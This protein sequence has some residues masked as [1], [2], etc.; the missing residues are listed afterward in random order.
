MKKSFTDGLR[1]LLPN[2]MHVTCWAHILSLVGQEFRG[3]FELTDSLVAVMKAIFSHVPGRQ[4]RY[5]THLCDCV[6]TDVMMPPN[7]V[8][9][10]WNMWFSA[11][12]YH[13]QH[14]QYYRTFVENELAQCGS[15]VQ[16]HK[17]LD[18]LQE[19]SALVLQAELEFLSV[20]C[21]RLMNTLKALEN[22]DLHAVT[23]HNT[24]SD[25]LSCL[26]NPGFPFA[27]AA[28]EMAMT[29]AAAK[30]QGYVEQDIQPAHHLLHSTP[31][32][33]QGGPLSHSAK[34]THIIYLKLFIFLILDRCRS[35][36]RILQIFSPYRT[37]QRQ[38][39]S[40]RYTWI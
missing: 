33:L 38:S 30:L 19:E 29:N 25:L 35:C 21:E 27:T 20:H 1:G 22:D 17:L 40:G 15:T 23:I 3:V 24:V 28:R 11:A 16:L 18:I 36:P 10:R 6:A 4:A 34:A 8:V 5:L 37:S 7:P 2:T 13:R 39:T 31:L 9:T 12:L 32:H 14:L 26:R